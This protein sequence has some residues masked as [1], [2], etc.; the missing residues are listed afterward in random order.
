MEY[1]K[2]PVHLWGCLS[3]LPL[4][5]PGSVSLLGTG[6]GA[7]AYALLGVSSTGG[8][9]RTSARPGAL[10]R[11]DDIPALADDR[12]VPFTFTSKLM[13]LGAHSGTFGAF[14]ALLRPVVSRVV[15]LYSAPPGRPVVRPALLAATLRPSKLCNPSLIESNIPEAQSSKTQTQQS[16]DCRPDS[17]NLQS[18]Y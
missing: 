18:I 2:T 5:S 4:Q 11:A 3:G 16:P 17:R 10:D 1:S 9:S 15:T 8:T 6:P 12:G 13:L 7:G 14:L